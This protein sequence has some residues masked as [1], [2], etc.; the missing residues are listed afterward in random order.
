M[1]ETLPSDD[2]KISSEHNLFTSQMASEKCDDGPL[3]FSQDVPEGEDEEGGQ[4]VVTDNS[5]RK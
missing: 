2:L 1:S 4:T 3:A 5:D